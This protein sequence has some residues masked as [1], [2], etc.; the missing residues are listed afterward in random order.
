MPVVW[1]LAMLLTPLAQS[2]MLNCTFGALSGLRSDRLLDGFVESDRKDGYG[3]LMASDLTR[4]CP[5]LARAVLTRSATISAIKMT[6]GLV[7]TDGTSGMI[8]ASPT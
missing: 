4:A 7:A 5:L 6:V 3:A 1:L 2:A 8:E